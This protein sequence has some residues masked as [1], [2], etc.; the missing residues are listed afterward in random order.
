MSQVGSR[1]RSFFTRTF[2]ERQLYIRS[3]G[4]VKYHTLSPALQ[5]MS[6]AAGVAVLGW[7]MFASA[8]TIG[9][10]A[11]GPNTEVERERARQERWRNESSHQLEMSQAQL[12]ERNEEFQRTTNEL[13]ARHSILV[14]LVEAAGGRDL[15]LPLERNGASM[16][17]DASIDEAEPRQARLGHYEVNTVA[18]T[19]ASA[20]D[21]AQHLA[22]EQSG[23]LDQIEGL[24][25]ERSERARS[26]LRLAGA[27]EMARRANDGE[28]VPQN[29]VAYLQQSGLNPGFQRRV[30]QVAARVREARN[31]E[32]LV[33]A[34]PLAQPVGVNS[35]QTSR[36]GMRSDPFTSRRA[37]HEGLDF[38]AYETAPVVATSPGRVSFA[39]VKS[40][41]GYLVEVDHGHGFTTR[42]GHL[43]RIHVQVGESVVIGQSIGAMGNTGRS[44]A[45]HL[46]YE[47][48]MNGVPVNPDGFLRAGRYVHEQ[49]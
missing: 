25:V 2:P 41:Y 4:S 16:L 46:H 40:G 11:V 44:T 26:L 20:R 47:V 42:Y 37:I 43:Q 9:G 5:A 29:F 28:L 27:A 6:A 24:V 13:Q 34:T 36:Y 8:T 38:A 39:G 12:E 3:G 48:R 33:E 15:G 22:A 32:Q 30:Q 35:R 18:F 17:M 49:G 7:V 45:T 23:E 10:T 14:Q 21:Q 1:A 19:T 31:L